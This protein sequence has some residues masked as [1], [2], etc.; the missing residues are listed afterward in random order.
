[1]RPDQSKAFKTGTFTY[2]LL[3]YVRY[4]LFNIMTE[5]ADASDLGSLLS[6]GTHLRSPSLTPAS[7]DYARTLEINDAG[8]RAITR[9]A[10][11]SRAWQLIESSKGREL[12]RNPSSLRVDHEQ[13]YGAVWPV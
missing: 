3:R 11:A 12:E 2:T 8:W 5:L 13:H 10:S 6:R 7:V 1:M 4:K 9:Q